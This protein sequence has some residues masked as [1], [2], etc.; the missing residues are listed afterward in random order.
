MEILRM[1]LSQILILCEETLDY[2]DN[3]SRHNNLRIDGLTEL[4]DE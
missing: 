4:S 3:Q 1:K 2:L